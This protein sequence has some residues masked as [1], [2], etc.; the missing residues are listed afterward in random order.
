VPVQSTS[1]PSS[2]ADLVRRETVRRSMTVTLDTDILEF[3]PEPCHLGGFMRTVL[4]LTLV[5]ATF[6]AS[7]TTFVSPAHL[8]RAASGSDVNRVRHLRRFAEPRMLIQ[9]LWSKISSSLGS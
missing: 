6:G 9:F 8:R 2:A 7:F 1:S 5:V 3:M 4:R